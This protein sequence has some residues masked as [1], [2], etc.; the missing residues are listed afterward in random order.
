L[1]LRRQSKYR[2]S[3]NKVNKTEL[4]GYCGGKA[5]RQHQYQ[6]QYEHQYEGDKGERKWTGQGAGQGNNG[7][8]TRKVKVRLRVRLWFNSVMPMAVVKDE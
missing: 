1:G 6:K 3:Y 7:G 2:R 5:N 4:N 8:W